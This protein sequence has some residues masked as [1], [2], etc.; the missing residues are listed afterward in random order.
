MV[1]PG[2]IWGACAESDDHSPW[3]PL[4]RLHRAFG[5]CRS[6]G[7]ANPDSP[8]PQGREAAHLTFLPDQRRSEAFG[9]QT[10]WV[11]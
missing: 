3:S 2:W 4:A 1:L 7:E 10:T 11:F 5:C 8:G 9:S 6:A